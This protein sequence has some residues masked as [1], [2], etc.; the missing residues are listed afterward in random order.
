M[1]TWRLLAWGA[2]VLGL[3]AGMLAA[4]NLKKTQA[5]DVYAWT[6]QTPEGQKA[7]LAKW[8]GKV[9]V[10]NFWASWCEPCAREIPHL[11][12]LTKKT[13]KD[14]I[15]VIGIA[16]DDPEK[17]LAFARDHGVNYPILIGKAEAMESSRLL[18]NA[19]QGLPFTAVLGP[20]GQIRA[21]HA[22]EM[23]E[24]GLRAFLAPFL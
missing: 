19:A 16:I 6:F 15:A 20:E 10:I 22:G 2:G 7:S 13:A 17:A 11:I 5:P 23:D 18:G 24:A 14:Q 1:K 21:N 9:L 8:R 4:V 12:A 3:L